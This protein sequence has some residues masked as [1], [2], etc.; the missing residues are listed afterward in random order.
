M[1]KNELFEKIKQEIQLFMHKKYHEIL[2]ADLMM[3][4]KSDIIDELVTEIESETEETLVYYRDELDETLKY[5]CSADD[6]ENEQSEDSEY[7]DECETRAYQDAEDMKGQEF[8]W[9]SSRGCR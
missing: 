9:R 6:C 3:Q 2:N 5:V 4:E 8:D 7:C 1:S